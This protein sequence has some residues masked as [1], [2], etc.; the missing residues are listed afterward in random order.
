MFKSLKSIV[1]GGDRP[2]EK[3]SLEMLQS[4]P[5]SPLPACSRATSPD[6]SQHRSLPG[7]SQN[8]PRGRRYLVGQLNK[9]PTLTEDDVEHKEEVVESLRMMAEL[10]IWG[11][12]NNSSVLECA[13]ASPRA[14]PPPAAP[15]SPARGALGAATAWRTTC[16][17]SSS[18]T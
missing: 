7:A 1:S 15:P 17:S 10:I 8:L 4:V 18:P 14:R 11:D 13:P 12:Q 16:W 2:K 6:P 3:Y 9:M 5:P